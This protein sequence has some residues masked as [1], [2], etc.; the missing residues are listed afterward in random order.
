MTTYIALL[1]GINVG[2]NKTIA[3]ADLRACAGKVGLVGA[4]T[5]LNSGN[6]VFR[7]GASSAAAIEQLLEAESVK[8]LGLETEYHVRTGSELQDAIARNPFP[9]EAKDDPGHLHVSFFKEP[10]SP[11]SVAALQAAIKGRELVRASGR[12]AYLV[13]PDGAGRSKLTSAML[14]KHLGRGT[15]R[16]WNTVMKLLVLAS[17]YNHE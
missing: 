11:K 14:D 12:H 7:S 4:Q 2:G 17:A 13:Y 15:A 8:R 1:R 10:P 9:R 6:L 16:N 5:L 3:M